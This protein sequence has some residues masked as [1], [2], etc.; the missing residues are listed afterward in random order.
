MR[1]P[2]LARTLARLAQ[3]GPREFYEGELAERLAAGLAA[4]GSPLADLRATQA[5]CE[6]RCACPTARASC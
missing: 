2:A 5:R 3:Q 4:A 1:L 6:A